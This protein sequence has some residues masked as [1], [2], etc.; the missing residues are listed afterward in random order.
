MHWPAISKKIS[1]EFVDHFTLDDNLFEDGG[2]LDNL[3]DVS[4]ERDDFLDECNV[5]PSN[6]AIFENMMDEKSSDWFGQN[7]PDY[8]DVK[9]DEFAEGDTEAASSSTVKPEIKSEE[10]KSDENPE[11]MDTSPPESSPWPDE[12]KSESA[13]VAATDANFASFDN[14]D[15]SQSNFAN[16]ES[17]DF[18]QPTL[19]SSPQKEHKEVKMDTDDQDEPAGEAPEK[20]ENGEG[21]ASKQIDSKD[22]VH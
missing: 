21:D 6:K 10:T 7:E 2:A 17:A 22:K 9:G 1:S 18:G 14:A 5:D 13:P 15:F 19:S 11:K 4:K 16:F 8:D 20:V 12:V 3:R